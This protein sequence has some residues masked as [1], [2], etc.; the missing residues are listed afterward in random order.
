MPF[1]MLW[2]LQPEYFFNIGLDGLQLLFAFLALTIV[3]V[4]LYCCPS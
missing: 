1:F 3:S 2:L 4:G